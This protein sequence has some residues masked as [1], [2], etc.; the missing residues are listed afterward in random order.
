MGLLE[1]FL[2]SSL[3]VATILIYANAAS[4]EEAL[5][6][7]EINIEKE[8]RLFNAEAQQIIINKQDFES[9]MNSSET[10]ITWINS[11]HLLEL[12]TYLVEQRRTGEMM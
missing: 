5:L 7:Q 10:K 12:I 1:K 6:K 8:N 3:M 4:V 9:L 11:T 2:L